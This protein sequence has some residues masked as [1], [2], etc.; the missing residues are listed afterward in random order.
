MAQ[1][2]RNMKKLL[3][4]LC[5][6]ITFQVMAQQKPAQK[7]PKSPTTQ[8]GKP[9]KGDNAIADA[10]EW[11]EGEQVIEKDGRVILVNVKKVEEPRYKNLEEVKGVVISDYQNYLEKEWINELKAKYPVTVNEV[12]L[13]KLV[14]K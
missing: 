1:L 4:I 10:I 6:L 2:K 12:E 5:L 11:K 14:K 3:S 8:P 7:K 9:K 13:K